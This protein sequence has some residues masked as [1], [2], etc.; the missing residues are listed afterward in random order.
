MRNFNF[1]FKGY[2]Y[3]M[4]LRGYSPGCQPMQGLVLRCMESRDGYHDVLLYNRKLTEKELRDYE[5]DFIQEVEVE[6]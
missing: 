5:M 4:R 6:I 1:G 2:L 3:G